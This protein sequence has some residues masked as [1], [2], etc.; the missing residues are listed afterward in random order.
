[1]RQ[2]WQEPRQPLFHS[3]IS[4]LPLNFREVDPFLSPDR[5]T[6]AKPVFSRQ[7]TRHW[8][9]WILLSISLFA[10]ISG[11]T[12]AAL[13]LSLAHAPSLSFACHDRSCHG[14]PSHVSVEFG[15]GGYSLEKHLAGWDFLNAF[16][17]ETLD[18]PTH[19]RVNYVDQDTALKTNLTYGL[20][21]SFLQGGSWLIDYCLAS[22]NKF[23]MRVDAHNVVQGGS[24]GR[25]SVRIMSR[26]AWDEFVVVLD[27][28]HMPE[29]C[30]T[31][32][33]FWSLSAQGP[34]PKG[35]EIDII[36]GIVLS[37]SR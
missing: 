11:L 27:L 8:R 2:W 4:Y 18:D 15:L 24:R 28:T 21:L 25:D 16:K 20:Y 14:H 32:P 34:W 3:L 7:N 9:T 12:Y 1:M 31:W 6:P 35:G 33:A 29:G 19:G 5:R 37:F 26:E 23:V 30:G 13:L 36:E 22:S 17:W 10:M